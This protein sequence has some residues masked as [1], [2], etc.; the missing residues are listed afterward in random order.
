MEPDCNS[1]HSVLL[2]NLFIEDNSKDCVLFL[3]FKSS[4][5]DSINQIKKTTEV[6]PTVIPGYS[7]DSNAI[8]VKTGV[9]PVSNSTESKS[10]SS[11]DNSLSQKT[12]IKTDLKK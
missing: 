5:I 8:S 3:D 9:T 2:N 12:G 1:S 4:N 7:N 6:S 11:V 10:K